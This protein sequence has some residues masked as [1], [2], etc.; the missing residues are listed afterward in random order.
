MSKLTIAAEQGALHGD[1]DVVL[2]LLAE[3]VASVVLARLAERE[4]AGAQRLTQAQ[5]RARA[6]CSAQTIGRAVKLPPG[7]PGHLPSVVA[8]PGHGAAKGPR[9][10]ISAADIDR[11]LADNGHVHASRGLAVG[12]E[13]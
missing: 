11:W 1:A 3:R 10:L 6:R 2:D 5:A 7:T 4:S 8:G 12:G 9:R 13:A